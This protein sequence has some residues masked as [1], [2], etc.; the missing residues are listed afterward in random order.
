[1]GLFNWFGKDL[2]KPIEAVSDLYTTDKARIA[3]E[4]NLA[5][6]L[7]PTV[8]GQQEINK[9]LAN[10]KSAFTSGWQSLIGWSAGFLLLL[11]YGPQI[12]VATYIWAHICLDKGIIMPYPI[13]SDDIVNLIYLLFGFGGYHL[14][15]KK[16]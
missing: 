11:Y 4:A 12:I 15:N 1:M 13:K 3:E 5:K 8:T 2:A 9:V 14:I 16:L 10:S 7:E 6:K